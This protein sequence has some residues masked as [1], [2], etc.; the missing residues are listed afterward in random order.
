[1]VGIFGEIRFRVTDRKVLTFQ[2]FKREVS[3]T[4]NSMDR[5][6]MKPMTEYGGPALQKI[7]FDIT[8]DASLGVKPRRLLETLERM[9]ESNEAYELLIGKEMIGNNKWVITKCSQAYDVVLRDGEVY[10]ATV[11]LSLQEYV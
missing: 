6:G 8:L 5:I 7:S 2:N 3:S 4:W 9:A 10:K 11:S 1:M